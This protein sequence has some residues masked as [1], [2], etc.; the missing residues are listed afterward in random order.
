MTTER[1]LSEEPDL[2]NPLFALTAAI[3][4][5]TGLA[6]IA[7][8]DFAV[9][10]LLGDELAG[11]CVP[12][13]RLAGVA[14]LALGVACW[15]ARDDRGAPPRRPLLGAMLLYNVGAAIVLRRRDCMCQRRARCFGRPSDCMRSWRFGARRLPSA[16][17]SAS[18]NIAGVSVNYPHAAKVFFLR[19]NIFS[20]A[21]CFW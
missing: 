15:L 1:G 4:A 18:Y 19:R 6:L 17:G 13:G 14:L 11:P 5:A 3:E 9:G 12:L 21:A 2:V 7:A 8:P 10:L 16:R 20:P